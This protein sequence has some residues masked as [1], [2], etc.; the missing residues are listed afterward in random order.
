MRL[1]QVIGLVGTA[2]DIA[3]PSLPRGAVRLDTS[4]GSFDSESLIVL[5]SKITHDTADLVWATPDR[6]LRIESH[7]THDPPTGVWRRNDVLH[8]DGA[9]VITI[10]RALARFMLAPGQYEAYSQ[11]SGWCREN[12]GAW[13]P[14]SHGGLT[15]RCEGGQTCRGASPF[16]CLREVDQKTGM[17]FHIVPRGNWTI[18]AAAHTARMAAL[19]VITVE[20]G[21]DDDHL[22]LKLAGKKSLPLP[23]ILFQPLTANDPAPTAPHLHRYLAAHLLPPV[24]RDPPVVYNTWFYV[25]EW[26]TTDGLRRQLAAAKQIGCEVF[27]V[28]AGWYGAGNGG[29]SDQVG[30]WREKVE[31]GFRGQMAAFA[32]EVR[33]AGLGFGLWMEPERLGAGVP[34][35]QEQPQWFATSDGKHYWPNLDNRDCYNYIV[36]EMS[37]LIETYKLVWMKVDFNFERGVDPSGAEYAAYYAAWYRLLDQVQ[38]TYP[39]V[40]LE[41]CS[42]GGLRLDLNTLSHFHGHF[43]SDTVT[44]LHVL[45]ISQG[46]H[47]RLP[48]GRITKWCVLSGPRLSARHT[49]PEPAAEQAAIMTPIGATWERATATTVDF[50]ARVALPGMFGLSGD[51]GGL[52]PAALARLGVHVAFYK[53]WRSFI[54][55]SVCHLLT[56]PRPIEDVKGWAAMQL[57]HGS[58]VS[59]VFAYR[60]DDPTIRMRFPLRDLDAGKTYAVAADD[61]PTVT[62]TGKQLMDEGI[63]VEMAT[64]NGAQVFV[65]EPV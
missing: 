35:V 29:W 19:P 41:G 4:I 10:Y 57:Q 55:E 34:I 38:T 61:R 45:R 20:L 59:L 31:G 52:P 37:R 5:D 11:S 15:L 12:Q 27:V 58:G 39:R 47:L 13:Q 63:L 21:L 25:N 44:P 30:D 28:D 60:L 62:L 18:R 49:T 43:L 32:A 7:W 56:P 36:S 40:F 1:G 65:I 23:L 42:S 48:P 33:A 64:R 22:R 6:L 16:L 2:A 9:K 53:K 50:A 14:I 51:L 26:F 54:A 46:A 8:N 3:G 24:R 17:A